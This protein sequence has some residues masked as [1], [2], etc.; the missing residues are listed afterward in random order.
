MKNKF[1]A[2]LLLVVGLK[3]GTAFGQAV[4]DPE[5]RAAFAASPVAQVVVTFNGDS[6]PQASQLQ[7]LQQLG[8]TRGISMQALPIAGVVATAAQVDALASNP[9]VR[10]LY[11]NKQLDYFN[12]DDTNLT[13]VKR[14]GVVGLKG[15]LPIP[16]SG[17]A[18]R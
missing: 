4:V 7:A 18:V 1:L 11:L 17:F 5:L 6:A 8:I 12:Y 14:L 9:D 16:G 15:E 10:S 2:H 3:A 13:G